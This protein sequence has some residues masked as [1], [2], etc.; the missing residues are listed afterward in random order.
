MEKPSTKN[1][2]VM[3]TRLAWSFGVSWFLNFET[4]IPLMKDKYPG[5][6]GRTQGET[7]ETIPAMNAVNRETDSF[8]LGQLSSLGGKRRRALA[9]LIAGACALGALMLTNA[10]A[11]S[12]VDAALLEAVK[13]F[14]SALGQK[15]FARA[16]AAWEFES[17]ASRS[18]EEGHLRGVFSADQVTLNSDPP[19]INASGD[20]AVTL[21][22][23]SQISE[24]RGAVEQ[25]SLLWKRTAAGWK[26]VSRQ[27]FGGVEGMVHL[28]LQK[29]GYL[30]A[31][32]TIELEDFTLRML[33]GTFF[34]N[35]QEAGPTSLVFVGKGRVTFKPRPATERGQMRIF[36]KSEVLDE[37]VSRALLRLHPADL[38][39]TLRPG[40]FVD[41]PN[42]SIRLGKATEFF[43]KHKGDAYVLDAPI[44]GA[45]WWLLPGLGDAAIA[46]ET[47]R[48]GSLT[49]SLSGNETE[50]V[51]LFNRSTGK[52][53]STYPRLGATKESGNE[54]ERALDVLKHDLSLSLNPETFDMTGRS[55]TAIEI[56]GSMTSFRFQLDDDLQVRSVRSAEGGRHLFFRVRGQNSV[57]VSMGSLAG[58]V[59]RLNLT[60]DYIGRLPAGTV[61]SEI[62]QGSTFTT[63]DAATFFIDPA[64]IYSRRRSFYPQFGSD[65]YATSTL[66]VT[67]PAEW[68]VVSGG[69]RSETVEPTTRTVTHE[70]TREGKYL[71]FLVARMLPVARERS[72]SFAFDAYAQS[73]TRREATKA[74]DVLK[75][76]LSYYRGLFGPLP[77]VPLNLAIVEAPVPGG[78]SPPGFIILQ[79]R[80][81]LMGGGLKDDPATFYD[82]PGFFL[83][84]ELAHQWWGHGVTPRSY[85]DR[86]VAEGFAQYAAALWARESQGEATFARVLRKMVAWA[87]RMTHMGPVDLGNRVGH[88]QNNPQA[89]RAIVYNKGALVLDMVRRLIGDDAFRRSLMRLQ[90]ENRFKKVD[91]EMVREAFEAE[92]A[93]ELNGLW[94][95]FVR[96]TVLP[97]IR[98]QTRDGGQ[99]IVVDGYTGP[100][101]VTVLVGAKRLDLIVPGRLR[102][103]GAVSGVKVVVDPDGVSLVRLRR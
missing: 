30:A 9:R 25:W 20:T 35:T 49:L 22:T 68:T 103:P 102:I 12:S 2:E 74:V 82:I 75:A 88:I 28:E 17:P 27:T 65:D 84:H 19:S 101:P 96:S 73:R 85:R 83:A 29:E 44:P 24:P 87:R 67:V 58:K 21:G 8:M 95:I 45:P 62:L 6:M 33:E 76:A 55:T 42:A 38:Y 89:H 5:T 3:T 77:Y 57:L 86:W 80:P 34:L 14:E 43:T 1:K 93:I 81:M 78:H 90:N 64:F 69:A 31:G 4:L 91:S 36:A 70:Q 59:G 94:E 52:Q 46:F 11:Q 15:D 92:G 79:R 47:K 41:D 13:A 66:K 97:T 50:G 23:L 72:E 56:R 54:D 39:R 51:S 61:D 63:E 32:Q 37:E 18:E 26:V 16:I 60:I 98:V 40:H 10:S 71:A 48:F 7:K 100:L 53:I 99:E